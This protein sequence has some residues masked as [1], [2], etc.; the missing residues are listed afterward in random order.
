MHPDIPEYA[1][2]GLVIMVYNDLVS[3]NQL[4]KLT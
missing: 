4:A 2:K 3:D 1:Y